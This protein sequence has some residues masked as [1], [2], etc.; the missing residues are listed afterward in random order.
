MHDATN[1]NGWPMAVLGAF[2]AIEAFGRFFQKPVPGGVGALAAFGCR[3]RWR[4]GGPVKARCDSAKLVKEALTFEQSLS[5][6][7]QIRN[8]IKCQYTL[9]TKIKGFD[10]YRC[11]EILLNKISH[12][13]PEY[14]RILWNHQE[15]YPREDSE[16][17]KKSH[18]VVTGMQICNLM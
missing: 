18:R 6:K 3:G 7:I 9:L 16:I 12:K 13:T 11:K 1:C 10:E 4:F 8:H 17:L 15:E 14:T 2:G 5:K